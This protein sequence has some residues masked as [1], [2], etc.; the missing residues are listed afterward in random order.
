MSSIPVEAGKIESRLKDAITS[1]HLKFPDQ[2]GPNDLNVLF[3]ACGDFFQMSAWHGNLF[4]EG[5]QH[6]PV[7]LG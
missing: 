1:A 2:P 6:P 4:A 7:S 5:G 3:L